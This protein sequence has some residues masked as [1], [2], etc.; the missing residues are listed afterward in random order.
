MGVLKLELGEKVFL[1]DIETI[2]IKLIDLDTVSVEETFTGIVHTVKVDKLRPIVGKDDIKHR[3]FQGLTEKELA[4]AK[5][6]K[7]ILNP[8]LENPSDKSIIRKVASENNKNISTI[9]RWLRLYQKDQTLSSLAGE[10]NRGGKGKSR[11]EPHVDMII[12][13]VIDEVFL[14]SSKK[15]INRTYHRIKKECLE[16]NLKIPHKNTV[17]NRIANISP[18][19]FIKKRYGPNMHR[20]MFEPILGPFPNADYPLS[21]V[22]IDHTVV[23]II[24]VDEHYRRPFRRPYITLAIDVFSRMVV[25]FYLSFDPPG[26]IGTGL[27]IANAILPK[28]KWLAQHGIEEEWPCWGVMKTI[29]VDNAKEFRGKMLS[30]ACANYNIDLA[31]RPVATP[32]YGGHVER[33]LGTFGKEI[34]DLPGTVFSD[35]KDRENYESA[36]KASLTIRE[37]EKW[38]LIY[39]VKIYHKREHSTL[40]TTPLEKFRQGIFGV[41]G[42]KGTGLFSRNY[43]ERRLILDFMP[44]VIRTVQEYGVVIDHIYYYDEVLRKYIH[45]KEDRIKSARKKKFIFRRD[46]RNISIIFFYD[47]NFD[48]YFEIPYRNTAYPPMSIWEYNEIIKKLKERKVFIDEKAIFQAHEELI[49]LEMESIRKTKRLKRFSRYSDKRNENPLSKVLKTE[50]TNEPMKRSRDIKIEPYEDA[51]YE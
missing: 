22:Q 10:K 51:D 31:F 43:D 9:Y 48:D 4:R 35:V 29:H 47:P 18:D 45:A 5:K 34:H 33:L 46:P 50:E 25:G 11:L 40:K 36:K 13:K 20:D 30:N 17:R 16:N 24:L 19:T 28:E 39:I 26:D 27:C 6:R 32:H 44:F 3:T 1:K 7:A 23:D 38:L 37:L 41:N 42:K 49:E 14:N 8:I 21:V 15:S 12:D 2:I